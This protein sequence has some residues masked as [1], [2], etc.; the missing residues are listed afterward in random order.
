MP[1][2]TIKPF[3]PYDA[4]NQG[5]GTGMAPP[6]FFGQI[7]IGGNMHTFTPFGTGIAP[8]PGM[9]G[10]RSSTMG[11]PQQSTW[12]RQPGLRGAPRGGGETLS[13]EQQGTALPEGIAPVTSTIDASQPLYDPQQTNAYANQ[14][15]S[16]ALQA[17]SPRQV[18][19][20][21]SRPGMSHDE[22]TLAA[23]MPMISRARSEAQNMLGMIPLQ[24]QFA[25]E[26]F[27]LQGQVQAGQETSALARLL[28]QLQQTQD[29]ERNS[30]IQAVLNPMLGS[31]FG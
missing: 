9:A 1:T 12:Q 10:P 18:M 4:Y 24:D 14:M 11:S 15:A 2:N 20:N 19:K 22:G 21:F 28:Q 3:S 7:P 26:N 27:A 13:G 6:Q 29:F 31:V 30:A 17:G 16:K 23:A 8:L 25:N 5:V